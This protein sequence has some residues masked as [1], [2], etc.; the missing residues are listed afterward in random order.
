M[1]ERKRR[2]EGVRYREQEGDR[3]RERKLEVDVKRILWRE[4]VKK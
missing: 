1:E 3:E 2:I 4:Y